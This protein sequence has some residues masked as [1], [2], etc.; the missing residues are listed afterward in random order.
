MDHQLAG[1]P[2][3]VLQPHRRDLASA[4]PQAGQQQHDG[5][6]ALPGGLAPVTGAE[7]DLD[8]AAAHPPGQPRRAPPGHCQGGGGK[9]RPGQPFQVAKAQERAQ[10]GDEVLRGAADTAP[11]SGRTAPVTWPGVRAATSPSAAQ[12]SRI[13]LARSGTASVE[14]LSARSSCR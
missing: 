5:V 8:I 6:I 7:Q 2:V 11:H 4:E 14:A 13:G 9:V 12:R 3:D 1:T 10:R